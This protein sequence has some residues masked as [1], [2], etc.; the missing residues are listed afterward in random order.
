M[1]S[2]TASDVDQPF[3]RVSTGTPAALRR[4][5]ASCSPVCRAVTTTRSGSQAST[6]SGSG[7]VC[8]PMT[9]STSAICSACGFSVALVAAS[10]I[11]ITRS[12]APIS[13]SA[14]AASGESTVIRFGS[15]SITTA[16]A[17]PGSSISTG[18]AA[19]AATRVGSAPAVPAEQPARPRPSA[20]RPPIAARIGR[21]LDEEGS[22]AV[23]YAVMGLFLSAPPNGAC[24]ARRSGGCADSRRRRHRPWP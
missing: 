12:V 16:S 15:S 10:G 21:R 18:K 22:G 1:F 24:G 11:A 3:I 9:C 19:G 4:S 8:P 13:C 20:R 14:I 6:C 23:E 2:A 5:D 7:L 17:A